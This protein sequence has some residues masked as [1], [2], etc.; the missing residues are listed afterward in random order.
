MFDWVV[1]TPFII[2]TIYKAD[3]SKNIL[4]HEIYLKLTL[5]ERERKLYEWK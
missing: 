1:N 3:N 4:K 5:K 2:A